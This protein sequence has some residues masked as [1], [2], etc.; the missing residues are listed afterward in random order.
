MGNLNICE[1]TTNTERYI[2]LLPTDAKKHSEDTE[3][4]HRA[5]TRGSIKSML[6][7]DYTASKKD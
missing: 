4:L 6:N 1:S 3:L 2:H 7:R 5:E